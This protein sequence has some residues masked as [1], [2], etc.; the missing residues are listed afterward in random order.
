[1]YKY[2]SFKF[3]DE[4]AVDEIR[5]RGVSI[6]DPLANFTIIRTYTRN[7]IDAKGE[8]VGRE[9]RDDIY[10]RVVLGT[11]SLLKDHLRE[12]GT[13]H[14]YS[15]LLK[16]LALRMYRSLWNRTT[17]PPGRGLWAMGTKLVN[18]DKMG[19][20]L[21]NCTFI[22]SGNFSTV[23]WEFFHYVMDTLMLGVGV[24]Y[25]TKGAGKVEI[26]MPTRGNYF[27]FDD[28]YILVEQL[29]E[30]RD[31][32]FSP[33]GVKS[34]IDLEIDYITGL[35]IAHHHHYRVHK[36]ADSRE[37]WCAALCE[38]L[39][40]YMSR[41]EYF[42]VF[43]YSAIRPAGT[44]LKTFGGKSSGPKPLAEMLAA[45]R[46]LLQDKYIGRCIDE[47]FIIDV[48]NII[49]R[50]VVAGNVRRSSQICLSTDASI[51]ECKRYNEKKYAYRSHWGWASNNS[52]T[53]EDDL[54]RDLL[55]NIM[56]NIELCGEP[57]IHFLTNARKYG[58]IHDG[59]NNIDYKSDGTNPC[60]EI[61]L[62]G[63]DDSVAKV[64]SYS[65][66]GE[67]CN[68]S[69]TIP[70]NYNFDFINS[71]ID[72]EYLFAAIHNPEMRGDVYIAKES[73]LRS[74]MKEYIDD[75]FNSHLY[76]KIVTLVPLHWKSSQ[77]IQELNRRI[78]VS[79]T[80]ISVLLSQ[81]GII[82]D[83]SASD[84]D[85]IEDGMQNERSLTF[86]RFAVFLDL[87]FRVVEVNDEEI[88]QMLKI[89]KSIKKRT[90]KPSGT[91]SICNN[92]PAG[93]HFPYSQYYIRR[94]RV[95]VCDVELIE[96]YRRAGYRVDR[97]PNNPNT[98][99]I[100]F[101]V[102]MSDNVIPRDDANVDLQFKILYYLQYYWSD[103]QVSCTITFREHEVDRLKELIWRYRDTLKGISCY[104]YFDEAKYAEQQIKQKI[105]S[106]VSAEKAER[107]VYT[108][109]PN[110]RI[111]KEQF[112]E[113]SAAIRPVRHLGQA[114]EED[115]VDMYCDGDS[116]VRI[117]K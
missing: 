2:L 65:A 77:H 22:T 78:G 82:G 33:P 49:A 60:G 95:N 40:S 67:T 21:V 18:H 32:D 105:A 39:K 4:R 63:T 6:N 80:G 15:D 35:E 17:T 46:Y 38:L 12:I 115:E 56:K 48:C 92:V 50:T 76:T 93:M 16:V 26:T 42:V 106:G 74:L 28:Y 73:K 84:I 55:D 85:C 101:P 94:V 70:S 20:P 57:G 1:M 110:E 7:I 37:G 19:F 99:A 61:T 71:G 10:R 89:P 111:T 29:K 96:S 112:E 24:G 27:R 86:K 107:E 88:S 47:L 69:E 98:I 104:P 9:G 54:T 102:K 97:V 81:M 117:N 68:L 34:Y 41:D 44:L 11:F 103:N 87:M 100:V 13:Y 51:I 91:V 36:I 3:N 66:G 90:V 64:V 5:N 114:A 79:I 59:I 30:F 25:D 23:K 8:P 108:A 31:N 109:L 52:V 14:K 45:I 43:D 58:R 72:W 83:E 75:I 116:C 113:M 53:I 62:E